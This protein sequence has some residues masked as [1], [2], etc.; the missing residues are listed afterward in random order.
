[1][2]GKTLGHYQVTEKLGS[3]GMGE[4]WRARDT[5]LNR[6]VALKFLPAAFANDRER[7]ARFEREAQLLAQLNHVNI[8]G[9][10]GLEESDGVPYLVLEYVPGETLKGP[11][12]VEEAMQVAAQIMAAMEEAHGKG[13]FH[14]DLKPANIK[15]TPD[16]KVKVLDFG[17]AKAFGD[18]RA[19]GDLTRSPTLSALATRMGTI[20]G[21]AA[22]M[23]PEQARGRKLDKRTDVWSFGCV[24][25][26]MLTGSQAFGGD[27]VSDCI[28]A[29]LGREPDWSRLPAET[30]ANV[31]RLLKLCLEKDLSRRL[32]DIGDAWIGGDQQPAAAAPAPPPA[33]KRP[34][35]PWAVAAL[36]TVAAGGL[37]V[38]HFRERPPGPRPVTRL[39]MPV[40]PRSGGFPSYAPALSP[41]GALLAF[42]AG[43]NSQI[44]LR[45]LNEFE[46]KPLPGT[47]NSGV[48]FF[49]PDGR[50]LAFVAR[51]ERKLK[52]VP[53]I[54][55][56]ALTLCDLDQY[57][58]GG[59][60]GA[61]GTIIVALGA[62]V[63]LS[64]VS[65]AGGKPELLTK[66][67]PKR[68]ETSHGWPQILPGGQ[69]VIFTAGRR[70]SFDDGRITLL[71]LKTGEQRVL[72]E[73]A[74]QAR[75]VPTNGPEKPE[76]HLVYWRAGSLFAVP[77]NLK[78]LQVT[79]QA[80]PI[81][82]GVAGVSV[83]G[84]AEFSFSET[85]AMVY[86][87][88]V[89]RTTRSHPMVW[90][91][92]QGKA[93]SIPAPQ[94]PY[95]YPH[96]SPD[97]QRI[98]VASGSG[99]LDQP[100][101]VWVY[102]LSRG[103]LTRLTFQGRNRF[104][105]WTRDGKR[106]TFLSSVQG[107]GSVA[108]TPADG[109]GAA[110]TLASVT[111]DGR[112]WSWPP[113]GKLLLYSA[114]AR[115]ARNIWVLPLEGQRKP[116][117]FI[118]TQFSVSNAQFSPDGR[119][120][121]YDSNESSPTQVY[122]QPAPGPDGKPRTAGKWQVSTTGGSQPRW[123]RSGRELFYRSRPTG[124]Q[125]MA[126]D[127]EPSPTFRA[128]VPKPLFEDRYAAYSWDVSADGKRFLMLRGGATEEETPA[129]T[130]QLHVVLEWFEEIKRLMAAGK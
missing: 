41:D 129:A 21:T 117:P 18:D 122:V 32:R 29:V 17:L 31:Q 14:R 39:S 78:T 110:E 99:G 51:Q 67:D 46:A 119:W 69:A 63:G 11:L 74:G 20:L 58:L 66:P 35:L 108:W 13:I 88:G 4:V 26:E 1:M 102:D 45:Q 57:A 95:E 22:Y 82:E 116:A 50:W 130:A 64:R 90:V 124:G 83:A 9:I 98:A 97:G 19:E 12:P 120:V 118:A 75:Y 34:W 106:V 113:D 86:A 93:E 76:G 8:G 123:A 38:I 49:S 10:H 128:G 94:H 79:G 96:L 73:G 37:A 81:L 105:I 59:S 68:G 16:G 53:V 5:R 44:H 84:W 62:N 92:R 80:A 27:T 6:D 115:G 72:L 77:F 114:G 30:P 48:S 2:T 125:V 40:P 121:A 89:A 23:S 36:A 42:V 3:G 109:S 15:I 52:K 33:P 100:S 103:A 127:I 71:S 60:W 101:D 65:A 87:P 91:D 107:K 104:P 55:G 111:Q 70:G 85:G 7:L 43:A 54:G 28:M 112:P 61:D 25:Y 24:L 56:T 47:E 126:V